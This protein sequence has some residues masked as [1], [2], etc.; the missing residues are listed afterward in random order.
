VPTSRWSSHD[1]LLPLYTQALKGHIL[2][3][4]FHSVGVSVVE[5][6]F[7]TFPPK[8]TPLL[9][10]EFYGPLLGGFHTGELS[11]GT[12]S[13]TQVTLSSMLK[14]ESES[15]KQSVLKFFHDRIVQKGIEKKLYSFA[16]FQQLLDEYISFV[17][18][19][20][21]I[22][23]LSSLISDNCLQLLSTKAGA[24]VVSECA[25]YGTPKERKRMI[26]SLKGYVRSSL[27]HAEAY[28]AILR[29]MD[30]TD[31]TVLVQKSI[32]AEIT[33]APTSSMDKKKQSIAA[34]TVKDDDEDMDESED[35]VTQQ[36]TVEG[37]DDMKTE[38]PLLELA[39][40]NSGSKVFLLLLAKTDAERKKYFDPMNLEIL[41]NNLT[42]IEDGQEVATRKK[43]H[44]TRRKELLDYLAPSLIELCQTHAGVLLLSKFGSRVILAVYQT[45]PSEALANA[46]VAACDMAID[47]SSISSLFEHP[48]AH[49]VIK[50]LLIFESDMDDVI[51]DEGQE[52]VERKKYLGLALYQKYKGRLV[53]TIASTSR[54][55]F[56]LAALA[57]EKSN[58]G[59]DVRKELKKNEKEILA[60]TKVQNETQISTAGYQAL[61]K[62][63]T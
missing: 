34:A 62:A 56:V 46:I 10:L 19:K 31:D 60:R 25:A 13:Y 59:L 15:S 51:H 16:F 42:I 17:P 1:L 61:V 28:I 27:L 11:S 40:S 22:R 55:A 35:P 43:N 9:K 6:L 14:E 53:K 8:A 2:K 48:F 21:E 3:L 5:L 58:V 29:L 44:D 7:L 47:D 32:L 24:K 37:N 57:S 63:L 39:L 50:N 26:K 54:G 52:I 12:I 41:H 33:A 49:L 23:Q 38:S 36:E 18:S 20:T 4:A 45:W 30:V